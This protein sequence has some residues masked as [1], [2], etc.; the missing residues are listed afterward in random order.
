MPCRC[1]FT[2]MYNIPLSLRRS[3]FQPV[4]YGGAVDMT[5]RQQQSANQQSVNKQSANQQSDTEM[6]Y[7][8]PDY[9][10]VDD[11]YEVPTVYKPPKHVTM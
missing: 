6:T 4:V 7:Q 8:S 2:T 3:A 5:S 1:F 9:I 10:T 11:I